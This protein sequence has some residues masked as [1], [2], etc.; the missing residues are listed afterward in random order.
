MI[1]AAG[2]LAVGI[3]TGVHPVVLAVFSLAVLKPGWFMVAV[4]LWAWYSRRAKAKSGP[5][6]E[7]AFLEGMAAELRGGASLRS[8]IVDAAE[9]TDIELDPVV[10]MAEAG[11]PMDD[12]AVRL[13]EQL[14]I[15]GS[16]AGPALRLASSAGSSVADVFDALALRATEA[17]AEDRERKSSTAQA[18]LSAWLVGGAPAAVAVGMFVFGGSAVGSSPAA[19]T[20]ALVGFGLQL[21]G[22]VVVWAM[23]RTQP[24]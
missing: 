9:R 8:A 22:A 24:W 15:N 7:A 4:A 11:R 18:R 20:V 14:P 19:R 16:V 2:L 13:G 21:A 12:I 5:R 17:A 23:V 1:L 6:S 3:A 10:R